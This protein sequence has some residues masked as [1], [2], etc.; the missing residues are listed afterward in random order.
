MRCNIGQ[1]AVDG[2]SEAKVL[3]QNEF[4]NDFSA[5]SPDGH[6]MAYHSNLSGR[7][8]VYVE[9]YPEMSSRQ[10]ISIGGRWR[11]V[12]ARDGSELFFATPDNRQLLSVSVRSRET[13]T[14]GRPQVLFDLTTLPPGGG[15]R[16][17]DVGPDGRFFV[18]RGGNVANTESPSNLVL[19]Q[20]WDQELK[21]L[22]PTR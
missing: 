5:V 1:V 21:R 17:Y 11:P 19:V 18:I 9:R 2:K 7:Y 6:W 15:T 13:L 14:A 8:E 20:N 16:P 4:C 3:I 22:V 12:W 10:Q